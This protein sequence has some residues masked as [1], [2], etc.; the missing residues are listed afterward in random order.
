MCML[1]VCVAAPLFTFT[2]LDTVLKTASLSKA[3]CC[4]HVFGLHLRLWLFLFSPFAVLQPHFSNQY[5]MP[6]VVPLVSDVAPQ[7]HLVTVSYI[8][9]R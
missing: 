3:A 9:L 1:G 8:F 7:P 2:V 6:V 4:Q 5:L